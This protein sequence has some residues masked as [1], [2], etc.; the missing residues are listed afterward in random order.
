MREETDVPLSTLTTLRL[1]GPAR[2]LVTAETE[3]E[4]IEAV[5]TA[6]RAG[7]PLLI[8]GGGSNVVVSDDGFDGTVLRIAT[9]GIER[10]QLDDGLCLGIQAGV[11]WDDF[12]QTAIEHGLAGVECLSGIPGLAGATPIQ[13][14]G[15]YGQEVAQTITWVKVLDRR[16]G[17]VVRMPREACG[18]RYRD[19]V[20]KR[21]P[22]RYV[23][24]EVWFRFDPPSARPL[25]APIRYA[26]VARA[27]DVEL[28]DRV[29]LQE[30]R[31]AVLGLRR[32]KGMVL[33]PQDHDTWS[34]GSFFTNPILAAAEF[35]E[36]EKRVAER[37]G[38]GVTPPR[39]PE[40]DGRVKT[41]A[42]WLIERAG[43]P[44]GYGD[45]PARIST[46]HTLALTNRGG[47]TTE[48]LLALARE[49]RDGVRAAFGVEL[50]NEPVLVG[51]KL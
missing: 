1:G 26:E 10:E 50:V 37:L 44:K 42:A 18:F 38:P 31:A 8:L 5:T 32:R 23:V 16:T 40:A 17:E 13:N 48:D 29:P 43:F 35:A 51:V 33:D 12:V 36:L 41:S 49:V 9:T 7:E 11:N 22:D 15:A 14:V 2:R 20:F 28:G 47:A 19:S 6:D 30:A 3:Q 46:K 21:N 25:S 34:A 39:Y 24:L 4:V 45:G 27:L